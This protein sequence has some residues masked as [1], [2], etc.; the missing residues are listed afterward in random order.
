MHFVL[1]AALFATAAQGVESQGVGGESETLLQLYGL[2][3]DDYFGIAVNAAGDVNGDGFQDMI[4]GASLANP[5]GINDAG[6]ATVFSGVDGSV[7][8]H[9]DGT[10]QAEWFGGGVAGVGDLNS[11]GFDDLLIAATRGGSASI[12]SG[13]D[14]SILFSLINPVGPGG[15]GSAVASTGDLN[16][17]G[18]PDMVIGAPYAALSGSVPPGMAFAYSGFDGS[19]LYQWVGPS[20]ASNF[21]NSVDSAGDVNGDGVD[22]IVIGASR[23]DIRNRE[24]T[25]SAFVYSGLDGTLIYSW[26][27]IKQNDE[28]GTSVAGVGDLNHDGFDEVMVGAPNAE[29]PFAYGTAYLFSGATGFLAGKFETTNSYNTHLGASVSSAGDL[30]QDGTPDILIGDYLYGASVGRVYAYSG[31]DGT[32]IQFW[33][34]DNYQGFFGARIAAVGDTNGDGLDDIVISAY[35]AMLP[36]S[37]TPNG[38][39]QVF[40]FHPFL[41]S[42][43]RM[44]SA[45]L[46]GQVNLDLDFPSAAAGDTYK[47]LISATGTGPTTFGVEIPLTLDSWVQSSF[48]GNYPFPL[49]QNLHGTLDAQGDGIASLTLPAGLPTA[50]I[51]THAYFAAVSNAQGQLPSKSSVAVK[52]SIGP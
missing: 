49:S 27:G 40:S 8:H 6:S 18:Y 10:S 23:A 17:D 16:L 32:L 21:G 22:D 28:F 25:G 41:K 1:I 45:S 42:D 7:I 15:F 19:L 35:K 4:V 37:S 24:E 13:A 34:G 36:G 14:G 26:N 29:G 20:L 47:V 52:L 31:T 12:Y 43:T 51:G 38:S 44:I 48:I 2:A 9:W 30:N 50:M 39:V 5:G 33:D 11:D 3:A 46:G